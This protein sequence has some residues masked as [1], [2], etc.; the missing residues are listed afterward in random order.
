MF[1]ALLAASAAGLDA[2]RVRGDLGR[3]KSL[4]ESR[5][6]DPA[7]AWAAR[8]RLHRASSAATPTVWRAAAKNA[9][10]GL[11]S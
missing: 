11:P 4:I 10:A 6:V 5:G 8:C 9:S 1:V 3:F 7:P 2:K